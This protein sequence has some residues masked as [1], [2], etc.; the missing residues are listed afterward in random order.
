MQKAVAIFRAEVYTVEV[1]RGDFVKKTSFCESWYRQWDK[2]HFILLLEYIALALCVTVTVEILSRHSL[3]DTLRYAATRPAAF[4]YDV[5]LIFFTLC[6]SLMFSK[7]RFFLMLVAGTWLGIAVA[8]CILLTFRSM[9]LTASDIWLLSSVRDIFEKYLSPIA[10][11]ILMLVISAL[12]ALIVGVFLAA[13]KEKGNFWFGIVH[14]ALSGLVLFAMTTAFVQ[15]GWLDAT[16]EFHS[17]PRAYDRNGFAYCFAA[18]LVTGG[19]DEPETY[20]PN[21]VDALLDDTLAELPQ[22]RTDAPNLIFVQLESFFDANYMQE[23]KFDYDPV[24]NFRALKENWPS[25]LL[26]VPC[27]GAGTANT[28]FEVLTGMN[29]SHFGVGE[30]PYMTIVD[31]DTSQSVASALRGLGFATHAIHNNNATFYDRHIVYQNLAFESFTS[32]EYMHD[33]EYNALGWAKDAVLT[34]EILKCLRTDEKRDLVFTVSVQ[35]HGK[36][37]TELPEGAG[38]ITLEGMDD[39]DRQTGFE[40]YLY[41]LSECDRF[42]GELT[43]ALE[44]FEEPTVVVFYGDHLPSFNIRTEELS[45]G[46]NQTTEYVIWANYALEPVKR[47]LQTYQLAAY[48]MELCGIYEGPMFRLHQAYRFADDAHEEY[49]QDLQL[50]EYDMIYGE[51]YYAEGEELTA[52][53]LIRYDVEDIMLLDIVADGEGV[54]RASGEHFTPF[55]T[56]CIDGELYETE[57]ISESELRFRADEID[58]GASIC[59]VQV[60]AADGMQILSE[61]NALVWTRAE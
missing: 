22:T 29:L 10:L 35:P 16:T 15:F 57:Y 31:S 33:A 2:R 42:V 11:A 23:L 56:L 55:S 43:Q 54:W 37:P 52:S 5:V 39:P 32:I 4:I 17:L 25:G 13:G 30:Y 58:L 27:I 38:S 40:Y 51:H 26:S 34:E 28:E 9:P 1:E 12:V 45:V 50:L 7:R 21:E 47:D 61:S 36:Y 8:N 24:P 59:V 18:S 41:E 48:A 3:L 46:D 49:Q 14:F 60:S 6:A 53:T 19:I 44:S 20:S